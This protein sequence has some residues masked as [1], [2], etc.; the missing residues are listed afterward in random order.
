MVLIGQSQGSRAVITACLLAHDY[1][2]EL[3]FKA[4]VATGVPSGPQNFP[5]TKAPQTAV[6]H[7]TGGGAN[8]RYS[9]LSVF[10][11]KTLDSTFNPEAWLSEKAKPALEAARRGCSAEIEEAI[12]RN[13]VTVENL[14]QKRPDAALAKAGAHQRYPAPKFTKPVFI[15]TGLAD[16]TAFPEGQYNFVI[17]ACYEGST[18]EAHYYPGM[19]HNSAV[20]ASL[21]DSIP[22]VKKIMSGQQISNNCKII[23]PPSK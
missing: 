22:F 17:A 1:A 14:F 8:A 13:N 6:P 16:V 7:Q 2:P 5:E 21:V 11:L 18:V 12:A 15:G 3:D 19:D 10:R 23:K 4:T 20:N 9:L